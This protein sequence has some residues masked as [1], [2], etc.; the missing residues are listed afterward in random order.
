MKA[1]AWRK[2]VRHAAG[3]LGCAA[4]LVSCGGGVDS[5]GTGSYIAGPITGYGSIVVGGVHYDESG[6]DVRDE[7]NVAGVPEDLKLGM[8]TEILASEPMGS[9]SAPTATALAVRY[10]SEIVGPVDSVDVVTGLLTV[11]GQTVKVGPLTVFDAGL[12]GGLAAVQVGEVVEVFG[13][14]DA[15]AHRYTA[16]RIQPKPGAE[17]FKLRGPVTSLKTSAKRLVIGGQSIDYSAVGL[18][19][20]V[21]LGKTLRVQLNTAKLGTAWIAVTVEFGVTALPDR[22]NVEVE[23]RVTA[24]TS[25][26]AFEVDGIPVETTA[27]TLFPDGQT[28]VVLGAH[29]EVKGS[30]TDGKLTAARVSL[31]DDG[32]PGTEPFEISGTISLL[33]PVAKTFVLRGFSVRYSDTT[34]FDGSSN[35]SSLRDGRKVEVKGALSSDGTALEASSIHVEL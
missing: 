8:F 24:F 32:A 27:D 29:V 11:L 12:A 7:F 1:I 23:G 6:A 17:V 22:G 26:A 13:Q 20:G 31:A 34:R 14:F 2:A 25:I 19:D 35:A 28:G 16:T 15:F 5:G 3:L 9:A 33:D 10:R 21:T 18:P 4:M 30:S